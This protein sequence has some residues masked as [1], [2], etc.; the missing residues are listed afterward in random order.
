MDSRK[1][2]GRK[3]GATR[4][5]Y[6]VNGKITTRKPKKLA[7]IAFQVENV[8][9]AKV[10]NFLKHI[11][12]DINEINFLRNDVG[13]LLNDLYGNEHSVDSNVPVDDGRIFYAWVYLPYVSGGNKNGL[14]LDVRKNVFSFDLSYVKRRM[15]NAECDHVVD[16]LKREVDVFVYVRRPFETVV[17]PFSVHVV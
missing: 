13:F 6:K 10:K 3:I 17:P 14:P 1:R 5:Y 16:V 2:V 9:G 15:T 7:N 4:I 12:T 11:I 8:D